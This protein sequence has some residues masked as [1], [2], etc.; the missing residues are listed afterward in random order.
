MNSARRALAIRLAAEEVIVTRDDLT[1]LGAALLDKFGNVEGLLQYDIGDD[2]MIN[3]TEFNTALEDLD[4]DMNM[5]QVVALF[6][7][8]DLD[9]NEVIDADELSKALQDCKALE[10]EYEKAAKSTAITVGAALA[11][12]IGISIFE[13]VKQAVDFLTGYI[14]EVSLSVDN[15][16]VFILLFNYFKV[17][18]ALQKTCLNYGIIGAIILRGG[19]IIAGSLLLD[20]FKGLFLVFGGFLLYS[21]LNSL[22][23]EEQAEEDISENLLIQKVQQF[24][25]VAPEYDGT[26]FFTEVDGVRKA[27]PLLLATICIE[28]VDVVFAVDSIPA[29]F[30][31]TKDPFIVFTSSIAAVA[32]LQS[33]FV[34]LA[35]AVEDLEYLEEAVAAVLGFVGLKL[36]VEFFGYEISSEVSLSVIGSFLGVG[37]GASLLE[38]QERAWDVPGKLGKSEPA[39]VSAVRALVSS[40]VS[41]ARALVSPFFEDDPEE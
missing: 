8:I 3:R 13:N 32:G 19:F 17:P 6:N 4:L 27:T 23:T 34:I 35:R 22:L 41:A 36:V 28:L 29:I 24:I 12:A 16:F 30:G 26:N 1:K 10:G 9:K 40:T 14:V 37:I 38:K 21:S 5:N 15:L 2:G 25:D 39:A 33:L 20:N 11:F 31:V 7:S 18:V